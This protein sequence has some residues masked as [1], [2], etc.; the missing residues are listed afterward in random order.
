MQLYLLRHG[1][2]IESPALPDPDRPLSDLGIRQAESA[3][4]L[5]VALSITPEII[6]S[7]PLLRARQTA[8]RVRSMIQ[9]GIVRVSE[10]LSPGSDPGGI[11]KELDQ[12]TCESALLVSHQPFLG[13]LAARLLGVSA[14]IRIEIRKGSLLALD[15]ARPLQDSAATLR[16]LLTVDQMMLM[17]VP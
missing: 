2:A 4:R 6:L 16:W 8:E 11:I 10:Y 17:G 13:N 5:L 15:I 12:Q 14:E 3:A 1:D 9:S 7:S